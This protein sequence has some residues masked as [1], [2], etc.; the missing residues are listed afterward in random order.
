MIGQDKYMVFHRLCINDLS[1]AG[2]QPLFHPQD[3]N[4]VV[5]CNGEIYN[6]KELVKENGFKLN[7]SSDCEV[8]LHMY[9][10]YGIEKTI[11]SLDGVFAFV[12]IDRT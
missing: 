8:I 6:Y 10:K 4:L 12:L 9:K 2:N 7:S 5:I 3:N 11:K 1:D